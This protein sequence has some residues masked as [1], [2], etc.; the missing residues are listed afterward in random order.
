[1]KS[2]IYIGMDV[3]KNSYSLC[4]IDSSTGEVI[5]QTKCGVDV[6]NILKF[7]DSAKERLSQG[8][9]IEV[10]TGYEAGCLGFYYIMNLHIMM[11]HVL[12]WH[13]QQCMDQSKI[14]KSRMTRWMPLI[15]PQIL[16]MVH[17]K[18]FMCQQNM[19]MKSRNTL[20]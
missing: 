15:L 17:T 11:Y 19:T 1:M 20:A 3:H 9:E 4:G 10:I 12:Y 8:D 6:K 18:Q 16:C 13:H 5:A 14:K 7:I 2:I